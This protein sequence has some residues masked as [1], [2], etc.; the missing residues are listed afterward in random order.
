M[1]DTQNV[2]LGGIMKKLINILLSVVIVFSLNIAIIAVVA[3]ATEKADSNSVQKGTVNDVIFQNNT[4]VS[5]KDYS[6]L[7]WGYGDTRPS[8]DE[9]FKILAESEYK[10]VNFTAQVLIQLVQNKSNSVIMLSQY[11]TYVNGE[12]DS[13]L[14]YEMGQGSAS[15][16]F[17]VKLFNDYYVIAEYIEQDSVTDSNK[18]GNIITSVYKAIT[19]ENI[20]EI[21]NLE[22]EKTHYSSYSFYPVVLAPFF[23]TKFSKIVSIVV[24]VLETLLVYHLLCRKKKTKTEKTI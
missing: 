19:P 14:R 24:L 9:A 3:F 1:I 7:N 16:V 22:T 17:L 18:F 20:A 11:P 6:L 8:A 4:T 13:Y 15:R 21:E 5:E 2:F 12:S 10:K 23:T